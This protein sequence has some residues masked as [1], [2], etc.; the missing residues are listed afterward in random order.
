MRYS[1]LGTAAFWT[2]V[3]A[4]WDA[5]ALIAIAAGF[6]A[7]LATWFAL[8]SWECARIVKRGQPE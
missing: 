4:L 3:Y 2:T 1:F 6:G 7:I 5:G 8:Y